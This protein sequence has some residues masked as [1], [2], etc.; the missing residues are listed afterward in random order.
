MK[1]LIL[2]AQLGYDGF[3]AIASCVGN[4]ETLRIE[5]FGE[6][7]TVKGIQAVAEAIKN[8]KDIV[9]IPYF[10]KELCN[11]CLKLRNYQHSML[12]KLKFR[13]QNIPCYCKNLK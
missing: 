6:K 2:R 12:F 5:D 8:R 3:L 4:V 9:N 1:E 11:N 13:F 10:K 7:N